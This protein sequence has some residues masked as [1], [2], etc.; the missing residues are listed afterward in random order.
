MYDVLHSFALLQDIDLK[1]YGEIRIINVGR[2]GSKV[3]SVAA[4][5][6]LIAVGTTTEAGQ[7]SLFDM[8]LGALVRS[9]A[10]YGIAPGCI[11]EASG[12]RFTP[13]GDTIIVAEGNQGWLSIF[14]STGDFVRTIT[15]QDSVQA[16]R[17]IM[18][19][20]SDVDFSP[21][22]SGDILVVDSYHQTV[23]VFSIDGASVVVLRAFGPDLIP[24]DE[25]LRKPTAIAVTGGKLYVLSEQSSR[26]HVFK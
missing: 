17:F 21:G 13:D 11:R 23:S 20:A 22:P 4:S 26:V 5:D 14:T 24:T 25:V 7:L 6:T 15:L 12:I 3:T 19:Q 1:P 2:S 10:P 18:P 9:F 16:S 8:E